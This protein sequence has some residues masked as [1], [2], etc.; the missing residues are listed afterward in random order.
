MPIP[1]IVGK[2]VAA[3]RPE[4]EK[5]AAWILEQFTDPQVGDFYETDPAVHDVQDVSTGEH[6][7]QATWGLK[8]STV[9]S[10]SM[11][12][13]EALQYD[14]GHQL[15]DRI[16]LV[17]VDIHDDHQYGRLQLTFCLAARVEE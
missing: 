11:S 4:V 13:L 16:D 2:N 9:S 7:Q 12:R 6:W 5:A 8:F 3:A 15:H 17:D 14:L 10:L 1:P